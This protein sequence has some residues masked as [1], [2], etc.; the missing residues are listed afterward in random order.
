MDWIKKYYDRVL[1]GVAAAALVGASALLIVNAGSFAGNFSGLDKPVTP[2]NKIPAT[3]V[4]ALEKS[5]AQLQH[6]GTWSGNRS[7]F[8]SRTYVLKDGQLMDPTDPRANLHATIPNEWLMEHGLPYWERDVENQDPDKDGFTNLEEYIGKTNP[9]K[10]SEVPPYYTKLRFVKMDVTPL[11]FKFSTATGAGDEQRFYI[12]PEGK[13]TQ[14][15]KLGDLIPEKGGKKTPY[16]VVGYEKKTEF[17]KDGETKFEL[18]NKE[19]GYQEK[20]D[21]MIAKFDEAQAAYKKR[22]DEGFARYKEN[23]KRTKKAYENKSERDL[24]AEFSRQL[25]P[26]DYEYDE[27]KDVPV[28]LTV[29]NTETGRE[30]H[31]NYGQW[32]DDPT[33]FA[34]FF[35]DWDKSAMKVKKDD[36]F[37]LP[38]QTDKVYKLIDIKEDAATIQ[39]TQTQKKFL[40]EKAK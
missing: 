23:Y 1:L 39:D 30:I 20:V 4:S 19:P 25:G 32:V 27:Y 9:N 26:N 13:P 16:K 7:V 10:A 12:N 34:E 29:K 35:Y 18:S 5:V 2:D 33:Y 8:V 37:T 28:V 3:D 40:I 24:K 36:T 14:S 38:P 15:V 22:F 17:L 21:A 31:L 11:K 6:P